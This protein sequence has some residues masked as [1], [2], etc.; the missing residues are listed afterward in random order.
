MGPLRL[1][2]LLHRTAR[3]GLSRWTGEDKKKGTFFVTLE[4]LIAT[5][6]SGIFKI[7]LKG[8]NAGKGGPN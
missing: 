6:T 1:E 5:K 7:H 4:Y 3:K 2:P 8:F